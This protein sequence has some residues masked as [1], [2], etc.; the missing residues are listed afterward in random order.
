[1]KLFNILLI[2]ITLAC[3]SGCESAGF[4]S[5]SMSDIVTPGVSVDT[6]VRTWD[7]NGKPT[8]QKVQNDSAYLY[9]NQRDKK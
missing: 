4:N 1:M 8:E 9:D 2:F 7:E 3:L 6:R 5:D